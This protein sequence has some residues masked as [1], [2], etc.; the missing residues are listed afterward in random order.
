M[1]VVFA[2]LFV[3]LA[4]VIVTR[5]VR[6]SAGRLSVVVAPLVLLGGF[7]LAPQVVDPCAPEPLLANGTLPELSSGVGQMTKEDGTVSQVPVQQVGQQVQ[8]GTSE[9]YMALA[10]ETGS[11]LYDNSSIILKSDLET[12]VTGAGFKPGSTVEVWLFS[13]PTLLGTTI[14]LQDGTFSLPVTV[15]GDLP[16][17]SHTL[18]AEGLTTAGD[19]RAVSAGVIVS[20]DVA[21]PVVLPE[22]G[23]QSDGWLIVGMIA[24]IIGTVLVTRRR[25]LW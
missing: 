17:G 23:S 4:G 15:P 18:Q 11:A 10:L 5:W 1:F 6:Q 22:T 3:L 2:G 25:N 24:L 19:L 16:A 20:K 21:S 13:T 8:I 9:F 7:V 14:V 12:I